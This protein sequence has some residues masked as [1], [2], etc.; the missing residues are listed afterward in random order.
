MT[1]DYSS[2]VGCVDDGGDRGNCAKC[3]DDTE[4]RREE[5]WDQVPPELTEPVAVLAIFTRLYRV[6]LRACRLTLL[7][8]A[9]VGTRRRRDIVA[10]GRLTRRLGGV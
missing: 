9:L 5:N 7:T 8:P 3:E 2:I 10:G 6:L 1:K 4:H